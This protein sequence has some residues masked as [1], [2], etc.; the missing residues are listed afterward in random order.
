MNLVSEWENVLQENYQIP[1]DANP[2]KVPMNRA[3]ARVLPVPSCF[4]ARRRQ[5]FRMLN[6][7]K[8]AH[9]SI[10]FRWKYR[11]AQMSAIPEMKASEKLRD[12]YSEQ[13]I[14]R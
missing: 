4:G 14:S 3:A 5:A 9:P 10:G 8:T 2:P 1:S 13:T 12:R 6:K 7:A 11:K